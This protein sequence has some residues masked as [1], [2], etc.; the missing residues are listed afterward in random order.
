M[1]PD[2]EW[3]SAGPPFIP[4]SILAT[5]IIDWQTR[6]RPQVIKRCPDRRRP[7]VAYPSSGPG[8]KLMATTTKSLMTSNSPPP[9]SPYARLNGQDVRDPSCDQHK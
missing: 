6:R 9:S 8:L 4:I 1:A 5:F 2:P 3:A 7:A